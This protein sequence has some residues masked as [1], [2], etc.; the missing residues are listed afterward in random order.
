MMTRDQ[1]R[2]ARTSAEQEIL[3]IKL[4]QLRERRGIKQS[5]I[6][7]FSQTAI[8][9]LEKRKDIKLSTLIDYLAGIG[10]GLE[11]RVYPKD[12]TDFEGIETLLKV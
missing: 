11:I 1:V 6:Q 10:M 5:D 3:T 2:R 7:S 12:P 8:S 9:K 4:T